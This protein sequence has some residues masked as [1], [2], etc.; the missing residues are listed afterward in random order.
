M[1]VTC[2]LCGSGISAD[3]KY[4]KLKSGK[5]NTHMYYGCTKARDK[6]CKCGYINETDLIK[7]LQKL[8]DEVDLNQSSVGKR[9]TTEVSRYKKFTKSLLGKKSEMLAENIDTKDY[10]KFLLK[11]GSLEEKREIIGC[12]KSEILLVNKTITF[13]K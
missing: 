4:K 6:H 13:K 8:L 12:F 3:E 2:G 1:L 9:I 10:V 11:E 5:V 7:Q